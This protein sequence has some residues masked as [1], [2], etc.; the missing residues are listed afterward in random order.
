MSQTNAA[1]S[2][3]K[4]KQDSEQITIQFDAVLAAGAFERQTMKAYPKLR[5]P[6]RDVLLDFGNCT[7]IDLSELFSAIV[8]FRTR[9]RAGAVT[10]IRLPRSR[11]VRLFLRVWHFLE[12]SA[13]ELGVHKNA[14]VVPEDVKYL[15]ESTAAYTGSSTSLDA[16]ETRWIPNDTAPSKHNNRPA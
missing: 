8:F 2:E 11:D 6:R 10:H 4:V 16:L 12:A 5:Q 15:L 14:L 13:D 1:R 7:Y 3:M 9:Q